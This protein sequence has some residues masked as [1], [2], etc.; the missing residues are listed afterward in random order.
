MRHEAHGVYEMRLERIKASDEK[1]TQRTNAA[2]VVVRMSADCFY[3][4]GIS[5]D[6]WELNNSEHH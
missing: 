1:S 4:L 6:Q 5:E 3:P 2:N